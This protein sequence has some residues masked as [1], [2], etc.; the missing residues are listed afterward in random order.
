MS[1]E[2]H[3]KRVISENDVPI[4]VRK[5]Y[6]K[7]LKS[8]HKSIKPND[9]LVSKASDYLFRLIHGE[10]ITRLEETTVMQIFGKEFSGVFSKK[11]PGKYDERLM[12][13][14]KK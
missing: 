2:L 5:K 11:V 9:S 14:I 1:K 8:C 7:S 12:E 6:L 3:S 10:G 13:K 4:N